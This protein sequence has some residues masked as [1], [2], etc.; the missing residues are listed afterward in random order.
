I[1]Q[2]RNAFPPRHIADFLCNVCINYGTDYLFYFPHRKFRKMLHAFYADP[3]SCG[4]L[5]KEFLCMALSCFAI[6]SQFAHLVDSRL[7]SIEFACLKTIPGIKF[8]NSAQ[9]LV[10]SLICDPSVE[11]AQAFTMLSIYAFPFDARGASW[12]YLGL[13]LRTSLSIGLHKD[14]LDTELSEADREIRRRTW[15]S[16]F[17]TER[18][19]AI[20]LGLPEG[21]SEVSVTTPLP[22]ACWALDQ[23]QVNNNLELLLAYI[24]LA[25]IWRAIS[26]PITPRSVEEIHYLIRELDA[27]RSSLPDSLTINGINKDSK[28]YRAVIHIHANYYHAWIIL[29]REPLIALVKSKM[30]NAAWATASSGCSSA[31]T[32]QAQ[33]FSD[34]CLNAARSML[35]LY[36][37]LRKDNILA[38]FSF[39]DF[40]GCSTSAI[41]ML[42]YGVVDRDETYDDYV[43]S[44]FEALSYMGT[45]CDKAQAAVQFIRGFRELTDEAYKRA[46]NLSTNPTVSTTLEDLELYEEWVV[47]CGETERAQNDGALS[48]AAHEQEPNCVPLQAENAASMVLATDSTDRGNDMAPVGI[49]GASDWQ[50]ETIH[51]TWL[52]GVGNDRESEALTMDDLMNSSIPESFVADVTGINLLDF[53]F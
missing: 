22:Q 31:G 10:P 4:R 20:K 28:L 13:A 39:T 23:G 18:V 15:W 7:S 51:S 50:S 8:Y 21:I 44:A 32:S 19:S 38:R 2:A 53:G 40:Q 49:S 6:G 33:E 30:A 14:T 34:L 12:S 27:W 37:M 29:C 11:S 52:S 43:D 48:L 5:N 1:K 9:A 26:E 46:R 47:S 35:R 25:K 24:S 45:G 36:E 17:L 41:I 42:L 16:I 3:E